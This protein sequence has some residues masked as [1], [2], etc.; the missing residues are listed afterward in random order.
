MA[1]TK[2]DEIPFEEAF[3]RLETIVDS[4]EKGESTL[5]EA[6]KAF[7][8]GMTLV[9]ICTSRLNEAESRLQRLVK[10]DDGQFQLDSAE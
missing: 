4:L 10:S 6:L 1:K 8:E 7:E 3:I 2:K 5:D 9:D